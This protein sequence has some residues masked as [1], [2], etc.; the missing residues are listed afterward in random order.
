[1][2]INSTLDSVKK[3]K[4][5]MVKMLSPDAEKQNRFDNGDPM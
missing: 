1:V 2:K 5:V 4:L 3:I